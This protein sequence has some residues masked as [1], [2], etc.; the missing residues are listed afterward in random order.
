MKKVSEAEAEIDKEIKRKK[1]QEWLEGNK[2]QSL[3]QKIGKKFSD[4]A[5][6][7]I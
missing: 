3:Y 4:N 6:G 2:I 5:A 7:K 1:I